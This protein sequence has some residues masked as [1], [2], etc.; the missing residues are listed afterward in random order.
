MSDR[1]G[2]GVAK[3]TRGNAT[4]IPIPYGCMS[5]VG[6]VLGALTTLILSLAIGIAILK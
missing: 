6:P 3:I 4:D 1:Q 5:L 2:T